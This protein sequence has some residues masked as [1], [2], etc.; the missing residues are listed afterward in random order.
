[1]PRS[2]PRAGSTSSTGT[3]SRAKV[4][5]PSI[6][7]PLLG[8]GFAAVLA[9]LLAGRIG[10]YLDARPTPLRGLQLVSAGFVAL[11]HGTNDAQKTMGVIAPRAGGRRQARDVRGR[12]LGHLRR[13]RR[14]RARHVRRRLADRQ[15][16]RP[17][18]VGPRPPRPAWRRR[19]SA[20]FLLWRAADFGFPISTTQ[21]ITGGVLGSGSKRRWSGTRWSVAGNVAI[22]WV[23]T[24]PC[25]GAG[26]R[27]VRR[28]REAA[29]RHLDHL[30]AG[31]RRPSRHDH[32]A[33]GR[34]SAPGRRRW[35][36]ATRPSPPPSRPT[37]P[38][39]A[40]D[41]RRRSRSTLATPRSRPWAGSCTFRA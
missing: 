38:R 8:F 10:R 21:V 35:R 27:R 16:G 32:R 9:L 26:R 1:M 18:S 33:A 12:Q 13:G 17:P 2:R 41:D 7:V 6:Y 39:S 22:A 4:I 31:G 29:G 37:T 3:A 36:G 28:G 19:R 34:C 20:A 5:E 25:A 24:L 23:I 30:R 40:S 14:D 11:T 15:H